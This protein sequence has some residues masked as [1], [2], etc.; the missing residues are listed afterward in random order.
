[1]GSASR[2]SSAAQARIRR[3]QA[4]AG[5]VRPAGKSA[6]GMAP[7]SFPRGHNEFDRIAVTDRMEDLALGSHHFVD[8][9]FEAVSLGHACHYRVNLEKSFGT[10]FLEMCG[11]ADGFYVMISDISYNTPYALMS[12]AADMMH[13]RIASSVESESVVANDKSLHIKG[14]GVAI[15]INPADAPPREGV[16]TGRNHLVHVFVHRTALARLCSDD[17]ADMPAVIRSFVSGQLDENQMRCLTLGPGF[18]RCLEDLHACALEGASRRLFIQAKA[19]EVLSHAF[20]ALSQVDGDGEAEATAT[21][22]RC[23]LKAQQLLAEN[24]TAPPSLDDLAHQVG[25]SRTALCVGFRQI[26]GQ[27]VFDYIADLRMQQ[28]IE[29][30]TRHKTSIAEI[31][32]MVGFN[33]TSSFSVAVQRRFGVTPSELRRRGPAAH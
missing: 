30:L 25:L 31:A 12:S 19:I 10:G 4:K 33:H 26:V 20:Q 14:P 2:Q 16:L 23:V 29:M 18:L 6:R 7:S 28:A 22:T 3:T 27:T 5:L 9:R 13:I 8:S 1:M 17:D 24:F 32:H 15:G 21:T 11:I